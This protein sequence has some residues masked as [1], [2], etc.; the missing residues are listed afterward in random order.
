MVV[1]LHQEL[2]LGSGPFELTAAHL[3]VVGGAAGQ[4]RNIATGA[5]PGAD[6]A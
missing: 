2:E 4:V 3:P 5:R 6:P 1:K